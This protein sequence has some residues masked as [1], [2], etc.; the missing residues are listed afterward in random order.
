LHVGDE[1]GGSKLNSHELSYL[2]TIKKNKKINY[3]AY[4]TTENS[5]EHGSTIL[6]GL[7][8][9]LKN[10]QKILKFLVTSNLVA[11]TYNIKYRLKIINYTICL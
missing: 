8:Y 4:L 6:T 10:L 9:F 5:L 2:I 3:T 7:V 11:H 1:T